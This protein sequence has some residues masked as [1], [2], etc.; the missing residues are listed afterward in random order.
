[1][2]LNPAKHIILNIRCP[3]PNNADNSKQKIPDITTYS[4]DYFTAYF[5]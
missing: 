1:M 3:S 4:K 2:N 5:I